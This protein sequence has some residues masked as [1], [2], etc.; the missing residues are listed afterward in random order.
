MIWLP[1]LIEGGRWFFPFK[2]KGEASGSKTPGVNTKH[3]WAERCRRQGC[4]RLS[5]FEGTNFR[6]NKFQALFQ[7]G[8]NSSSFQISYFLKMIVNLKTMTYAECLMLRAVEL[9]QMCTQRTP[10]ALSRPTWFPFVGSRW[11]QFEG[12]CEEFIFATGPEEATCKLLKAG[13]AAAISNFLHEK[14]KV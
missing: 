14:L 10:A 6:L 4:S 8:K 3:F 2:K 5:A 9:S 11:S 12:R 1:S 13:S 7:A